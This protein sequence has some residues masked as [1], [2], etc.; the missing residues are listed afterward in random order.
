MNQIM[1]E[2][3]NANIEYTSTSMGQNDI[4]E[5]ALIAKD[6]DNQRNTWLRGENDKTRRKFLRDITALT[7]AFTVVRPFNSIL[8]AS[9]EPQEVKKVQNKIADD[10]FKADENGVYIIKKTEHKPE[11]I[12][13]AIAEIH[14]VKYQPP[15]DRWLNLPLTHEALAKEGGELKVVMLGDSIVN[16]TYRSQWYDL[17]QAQYPKCKITAVAVVRG[18]TG[19]W[20]Y[21]DEGRV[22]R[23]VLPQKT[24]LLI[25]GGI[26][27]KE[28]MD[29]FRMVIQQ[30]RDAQPCD[31][32][33][34]SGAFGGTDPRNDMQWSYDIPLTTGNYR[35][36]LLDLANEL[37]TGFLDMT[38]YWG[39]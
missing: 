28:E 3:K 4:D 17:F 15:S 33:L 2:N 21:K 16:D 35:K 13:A 7:A 12:S 8:A 30:V 5:N 1:K 26:S 25:I 31:M 18:G 27:Q 6:I 9:P 11:E 10:S 36:S 20:W 37:H 24:D 39:Q 22:K 14:P 32:L 23:Y 19:C 34:M 29:S 38:A